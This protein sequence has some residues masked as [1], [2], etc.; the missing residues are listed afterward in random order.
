[1]EIPDWHFGSLSALSQVL[2]ARGNDAVEAGTAVER[3]GVSAELLG[4]LL[5]ALGG[6]AGPPAVS[7]LSSRRLR[8]RAGEDSG[9]GRQ[10]GALPTAH[11]GHWCSWP[12]WRARRS[13]YL[14]GVLKPVLNPSGRTGWTSRK[15][16][17][18]KFYISFHKRER[19]VFTE[20]PLD[21][22]PLPLVKEKC[23]FQDLERFWNPDES[24]RFR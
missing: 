23:Y 17:R 5:R 21:K 6:G 24:E 8:E 14:P 3:R 4:A 11:L 20:S 10:D 7:V 15:D 2:R 13:G 18:E 9:R 12:S 19:F 1:M 16:S 22:D